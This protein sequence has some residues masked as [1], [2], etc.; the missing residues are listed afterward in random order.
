MVVGTSRRDVNPSGEAELAELVGQAF[1]FRQHNIVG[2]AIRFLTRDRAGENIVSIFFF[3]TIFSLP[4]ESF[5]LQ[6]VNYSCTPAISVKTLRSISCSGSLGMTYFI[7]RANVR[8]DDKT[9]G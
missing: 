3:P 5:K 7:F 2:A 6:V 4:S 1:F 8:L 9:N